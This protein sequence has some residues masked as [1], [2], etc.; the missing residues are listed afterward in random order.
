MSFRDRFL[1]IFC[2]L[3]HRKWWFNGENTVFLSKIRGLRASILLAKKSVIK[4]SSITMAG[5]QH[6]IILNNCEIFNCN[7]YLRGEG[8]RLVIEDGV[9]LHNVSIRIIGWDNL[10]HISSGSTF[11]SGQVVCG[12]KGISI[13]VGKNCMFAGGT[14]IWSTDTHSVLQDGV[15]VN[16]TPLTATS[17]VVPAQADG[18]YQVS[19]VYDLGESSP[20]DPCTVTGIA[21]KKVASSIF[22]SDRTIVVSAPEVSDISVVTADGRTVCRK[23]EATQASVTVVPGVY[24]VT[25]GDRRMKVNVK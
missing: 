1:K 6:N 10:I 23:A 4:K 13:K 18:N 22:V 9:R 2:I 7:I 19:V 3:T 21:Q 11:G 17:Y 12:G 14:D 24:V 25:V 8:H 16:D 20:S 5:K 15:L